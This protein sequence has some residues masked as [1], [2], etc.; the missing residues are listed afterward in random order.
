MN[1]EGFAAYTYNLM[2]TFSKVMLTDDTRMEWQ[3]TK[4]KSRH[5]FRKQICRL[6]LVNIK[7]ADRN[8]EC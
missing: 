5:M 6:N 4:T 2:S 8:S 7:P 1:V 3:K